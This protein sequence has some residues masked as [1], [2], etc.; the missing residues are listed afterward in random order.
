MTDSIFRF[1]GY[2]SQSPSSISCKRKSISTRAILLKIQITWFPIS[3][4]I[5]L[6]KQGFPKAHPGFT[7]TFK[8]S[9]H[10]CLWLIPD[11]ETW[12]FHISTS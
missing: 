4:L 2:F 8:K 12:T 9:N 1:L 7:L 5:I 3:H 6:K 10:S 11:I